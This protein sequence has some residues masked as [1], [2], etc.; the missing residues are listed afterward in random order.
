VSPASA[1][2]DMDIDA[3]AAS[4]ELFEVAVGFLSGAQAAALTHGELEQRLDTDGRELLRQLLGEHLA[5]RAAREP[6]LAAVVDAGGV[7]RTR[8]EAGHTRTLATVFGPVAVQRLAYRAR[9]ATNLHPADAV[10]NLPPERYS[11][12]LRRL[13]AIEA[14][15]GSFD[16]AVTAVSRATGQELGKRQVEELTARTAVDFEDFYATRRPAPAPDGDLLVLSCD[17]KGVVMRPDAL[18]PATRRAAAAATPKLATRLSKGEKRNRK[19]M[20]EVGAVYDITP[21][22]RTG[23]DILTLD[24]A[25]GERAPAPKAARKWLTASVTEDTATVVA[26]VFDE[27][28]RRDPDQARTWLALLDG[29]NHQIECIGTEARARAVTVHILIDFIHVLEYLW[30]AAW[31]FYDEGEAAAETWVHDKALAVLAGRART[32]AAAIRR[33]ATACRLEPKQ[34]TNADTTA[35]YLTNK[36]PYLDYATALAS[37]WP[38]AT[39]VIEG[40]CRH[41]VK[42]RMDLTG[43]RWGLPG[44]EAILKL[45]AITSNGDFDEYWTFHLHNEKRRNHEARYAAHVIPQAA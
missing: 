24:E 38:I 11:H 17:G 34:R 43:A 18:R 14:T 15:R 22:V 12:G 30:R 21:A 42:D 41:L 20:A 10:L 39:G 31:S 23:A 7:E 8:V 2:S 9:G 28:Q 13:A 33:K 35:A 29:N 36:A 26:K 45:R 3:F 5:L 40:A 27:A 25:P 4:R 16:E 19:R 32:V 44:A 6:R 1:V 37:G